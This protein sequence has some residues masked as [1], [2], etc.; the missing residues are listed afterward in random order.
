MFLLYNTVNQPYVCIYPLVLE[1][2]HDPSP[3]H[4]V[5][6]EQLPVLHSRVS[7]SSVYTS[8]LLS[9]FIP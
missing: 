3:L 1:H 8:M 4:Q 9:Q 7:L 6:T 2:S 5:I